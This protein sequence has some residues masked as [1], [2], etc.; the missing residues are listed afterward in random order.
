MN[1]LVPPKERA[2]EL[3]PRSKVE[4]ICS[5]ASSVAILPIGV[6]LLVGMVPAHAVRDFLLHIGAVQLASY[7]GVF[8]GYMGRFSGVL[9]SVSPDIARWTTVVPKDM[10]SGIYLGAL[11]LLMTSFV[12]QV[13]F[14]MKRERD[15]Q[16]AVARRNIISW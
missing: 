6:L 14:G 3:A 7:G 15:Y 9:T 1:M 2:I 5:V 8:D 11:F 4:R 10:A 12:M 13:G 16:L